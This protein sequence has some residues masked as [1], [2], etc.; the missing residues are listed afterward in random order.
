MAKIHPTVKNLLTEI[1]AYCARSQIT[2][3]AFGKH[4]MND[5]NFVHR[6]RDGR[7]PGITTIERVNAYIAKRSKAVIK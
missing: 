1:E 7:I 2:P 3:T 6:L 5:G 4:V